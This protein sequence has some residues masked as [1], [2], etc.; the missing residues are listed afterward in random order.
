MITEIVT[1]KTI[2]DISREEFLAIVDG[3]EKNFHSKQDGF[4]DTELL[5]DKKNGQWLMIQHWDSAE[6][7][8]S[9]SQRMFLDENAAS[10]IQALDRTT[11]K[12]QIL[13]Q[14]KSGDR[15]KGRI[16]QIIVGFF[17]F[18]LLSKFLSCLLH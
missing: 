13:P 9:A 16:P 2:E 15:P 12:M 3:L 10:F 6:Q 8:K 14:I 17:P 1:M 5:E 4:V 18:L 11:V 7:L